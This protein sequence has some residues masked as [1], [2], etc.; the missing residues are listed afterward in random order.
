MSFKKTLKI[1]ASKVKTNNGIDR[2]IS[3]YRRPFPHPESI[4]NLVRDAKNQNQSK[5]KNILETLEIKDKQK[6]IILKTIPE[7]YRNG[8]TDFNLTN[9]KLC[10][11]TRNAGVATQL[12][13]IKT[14]ILD[15]L[16]KDG[17]WGIMSIDI[18]VQ[19]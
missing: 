1:N 2:S 11:L 13:Y 18:K 3:A 4:K 10:L 14:D 8:I 9:N 16:R 19:V 17:M 6:N 5:L 7:Q 15:M 12:R